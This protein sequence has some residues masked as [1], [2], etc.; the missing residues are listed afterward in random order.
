ML[1]E[2]TNRSFYQSFHSPTPIKYEQA[3]LQKMQQLDKVNLDIGVERLDYYF[4]I[5][6]ADII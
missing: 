5:S 2:N 1:S 3:K 6:L 4:S